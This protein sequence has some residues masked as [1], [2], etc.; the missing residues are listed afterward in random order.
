MLQIKTLV[1]GPVETNAYIVYDTKEKTA[2]VIDPAWDGRT[3]AKEIQAE[4]LD[5]QGI[6]LTHA[7]FD[8][9]AGV[10]D[11]LGELRSNAPVALHSKDMPLWKM[12]GGAALF[13]ISINRGPTPSI[14]VEHGQVLPVGSYR[15][16]VR[17][18]PGHTPGHVVYVCV[19]EKVAFCGDVIFNG[20]VGRTDLPGGSFPQLME[21]IALQVMT[22]PDETKIFSGHGPQTT[23]GVE[24]RENPFL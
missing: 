9:F 23:V 21:S 13:G 24:R 14:E 15:F 10:A 1:L 7:H 4:D 19:A 6:W 17:H 20:S 16:E 22:L 5:L 18:S 11:L 12:D 3:I 2:V 8:H